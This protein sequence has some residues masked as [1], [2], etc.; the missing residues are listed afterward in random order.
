MCWPKNLDYNLNYH[1]CQDKVSKTKKKGEG[2]GDGPFPTI[3]FLDVTSN[4]LEYLSEAKKLSQKSLFGATE[5]L[6]P[7]PPPKYQTMMF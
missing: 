5:F 6:P 1:A 2:E 7:S 4:F 3:V